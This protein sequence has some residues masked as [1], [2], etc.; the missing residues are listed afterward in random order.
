MGPARSHF[1]P[2]KNAEANRNLA[3]RDNDRRERS[4]GDLESR[5]LGITLRRTVQSDV[6]VSKRIG[7]SRSAL[8]RHNTAGSAGHAG[9][10]CPIRR[11]R[12][13]T[14]KEVVK[15]RAPITT[16]LALVVS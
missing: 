14:G 16:R 3:R 7:F 5:R 9:R 10:A 11:A 8:H 4:S 15:A 2:A 6:W 1:A 12:A 13:T